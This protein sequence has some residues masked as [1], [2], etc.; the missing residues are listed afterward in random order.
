MSKKNNIRLRL[1]QN[2][3][4]PAIVFKAFTYSKAVKKKQQHP[5]T[6]SIPA[7]HCEDVAWTKLD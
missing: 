7:E 4:I 2:L 1:V 5:K 6:R 3:N